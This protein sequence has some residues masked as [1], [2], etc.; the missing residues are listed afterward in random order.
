MKPVST[1]SAYSF[2]S[3]Q[4]VC[5]EHE[6]TRLYAEVIEVV[7][8]RQ[9]CWIRPLLLAVSVA[10]PE[11]QELY[12]LHQGPDLLWPTRLLR[13]ALDTE[14][15]PLLLKIDYLDSKLPDNPTIHERLSY[16]ITEIWQA[17]PEEF[18]A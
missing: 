18:G 9:V 10:S 4:I 8:L 7:E 3:H 6:T 12:D 16:F 11:S 15:I 13:P 1:L 17:H 14:V 2:Q 5:L